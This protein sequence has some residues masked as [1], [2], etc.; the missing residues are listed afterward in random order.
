MTATS[1]SART[2]RP[3]DPERRR[4]REAKEKGVPWQRWGPYLAEREWGNP[5]ED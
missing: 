1:S 4:L 3:S 5:R 2:R